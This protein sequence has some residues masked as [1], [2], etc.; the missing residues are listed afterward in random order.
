MEQIDSRQLTKKQ[1]L[2]PYTDVKER[3]EKE[4]C[5]ASDLGI[6]RTT[7]AR[8]QMDEPIPR[9]WAIIIRN[10]VHKGYEFGGKK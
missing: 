9:A 10:L 3:I 4:K 6:E 1:A 8:W 5:L 7:V 2:K